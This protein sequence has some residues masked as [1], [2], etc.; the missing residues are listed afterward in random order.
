MNVSRHA[1]QATVAI[2]ATVGGCTD[3]VPQRPSAPTLIPTTVRRPR[4]PCADQP[5]PPSPPPPAPSATHAF[6]THP[7]DEMVDVPAGTFMMGCDAAAVPECAPDAQP[8]HAVTLDAYAID[9][10]EVTVGDFALC[11]AAKVCWEPAC[12][13]GENPNEPM[14]CVRGVLASA[15]C[16]W[17]GKR[18]P[19]EAEWERAARGLDDRPFPWGRQEPHGRACWQGD[20]PCDVGSFPGGVSPVGAHDMAGNVSEWVK[21]RY[22]PDFYRHS[23]RRNPTGYLGPPLTLVVCNNPRCGI[24]RGGS[25]TDPLDALTTTARTE[26]G[27]AHKFE[28]SGFRCARSAND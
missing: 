11:L 17:V 4:E 22:K 3:G 20:G 18:L 10:Y 2:L 21:D 12:P 25:W 14:R 6:P 23:P 28:S 27:V 24:T 1:L 26:R 9:K 8:R 15:Y 5:E 7:R 16:K 19:W 13:L